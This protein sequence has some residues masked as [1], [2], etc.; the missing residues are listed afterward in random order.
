MAGPQDALLMAD[1][2]K[3][4]QNGLVLSPPP[5]LIEVDEVPRCLVS[6]LGPQLLTIKQQA[7]ASDDS[8]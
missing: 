7:T 5:S 2:L 4:K 6:S 1:G 8:V 3:P